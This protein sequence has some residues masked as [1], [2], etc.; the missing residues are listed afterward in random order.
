MASEEALSVNVDGHSTHILEESPHRR[1]SVPRS[2][3]CRDPRPAEKPCR[4]RPCCSSSPPCSQ[5]CRACEG[6][7]RR[8]REL[9]SGVGR[10]SMTLQELFCECSEALPGG[11]SLESNVGKQQADCR[12]GWQLPHPRCA[13]CY[14]LG[15]LHLLSPC[16]APGRLG[17]ITPI[18]R[19][20]KLVKSIR[21]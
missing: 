17:G 21:H 8:F 13:P 20:E 2:Q 16:S 10:S 12:N 18:F 4:R 11:S 9:W 15:T 6:G 7:R 3:T 14:M 1:P 5:D 19:D